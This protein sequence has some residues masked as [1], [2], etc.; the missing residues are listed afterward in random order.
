MRESR[1]PL[2]STSHIG[3]I[4]MTNDQPDSINVHTAIGSVDYAAKKHRIIL[5]LLAY[6]AIFGVI[7]IFLPEEGSLLDFVVG[8]PMLILGISWCFTDA[9]QHNHQIG[10]LM[11]FVL[12]LLFIIG[13]PLYIFQTRGIRGFKILALTVLLMTAMA[14][15]AFCIMLATL[16]IGDALGLFE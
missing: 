6:S 10:K 8:L 15:C 2:K 9:D 13:F 3:H 16:Y 14:V 12:V 4:K 5:M 7:C 11:R 1:Q